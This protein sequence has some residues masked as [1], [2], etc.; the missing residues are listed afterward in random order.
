MKNLPLIVI[1][2]KFDQFT[3]AKQIEK[4]G[5]GVTLDI[6]NLTP[7]ILLSTENQFLEF[8]EKFSKMELI[9]W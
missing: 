1:P 2:L 9:N 7:E 3:N 5:A 8:K 6:N 4:N